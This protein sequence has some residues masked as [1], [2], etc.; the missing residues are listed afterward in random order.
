MLKIIFSCLLLFSTDVFSQKRDF[1]KELG[2]IKIN[3][4]KSLKS[5]F[6]CSPKNENQKLFMNPEITSDTW[7]DGIGTSWTF[8]HH[9]SKK[10][11]GVLYYKGHLA[12]PRGGHQPDVGYI[13]PE[14]WNCIAN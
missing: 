11:A 1:E 8:Y 10:I 5:K 7:D 13:D 4:K 6:Q 2:E 14:S 12:S 3:E 9:S